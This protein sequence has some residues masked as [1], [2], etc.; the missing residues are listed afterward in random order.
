MRILLGLCVVLLM[1]GCNLVTTDQPLFFAS[2]A[3]DAPRLR[4]GLWVID[5][6]DGSDC[7]FDP[8]MPVNRWPDCADWMLVRDGELLGYDPPENEYGADVGEWTR[9]LFI[10]AAG[11]PMVLQFEEPSNERPTFLFLGLE[12]TAGDSTRII[13]IRTWPVVCGPP[14]PHGAMIGDKRRYVTLDPLPGL[15]VNSERGCTATEASVVRNAAS[16]SRSRANDQVGG[17]HW[18]RDTYP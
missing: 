7:R 12:A 2:D 14:P 9:R 8:G 11:E 6:V 5:D 4:N 10:L 1:G 3:P 15:I 13:A 18:I 17:A 16:W